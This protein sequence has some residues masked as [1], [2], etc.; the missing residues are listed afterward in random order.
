MP[1]SGAMPPTASTP[2]C[3]HDLITATMERLAPLLGLRRA[4]E[5][6]GCRRRHAQ[7]RVEGVSRCEAGTSVARGRQSLFPYYRAAQG[8]RVAD[9]DRRP[10]AS[11]TASCCI[12]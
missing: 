6:G 10:P 3:Q 8:K 4:P 9:R 2:P 7:G 12:R 5:P 1:L 11:F